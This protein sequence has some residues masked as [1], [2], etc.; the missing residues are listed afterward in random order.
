[1]IL[2][3]GTTVSLQIFVQQLPAGLDPNVFG[4]SVSA[5]AFIVLSYVFPDERNKSAEIK[6]EGLNKAQ[7]NIRT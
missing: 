5:I 3:G 6:E 7:A 2:G 1:M 4:I